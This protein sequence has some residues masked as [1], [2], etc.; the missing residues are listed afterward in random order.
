MA[1]RRLSATALGMLSALALAAPTQAQEP[2]D[3]SFGAMACQLSATIQS[4]VGAIG[5][6]GGI[7][8][9]LGAGALLDID[10]HPVSFDGTVICTGVDIAGNSTPIGLP[11][12]SGAEAVQYEMTGEGEIDSLFCGT[13]MA[14][15]AANIRSSDGIE[16][17][18]DLDL[19]LALVAG[20]GVLTIQ[21]TN[22]DW[23][24]PG[25]I[26]GQSVTSGTGGGVV[27]A[28]PD[29]FTPT[30]RNCVTSGVDGFHVE[31]AFATTFSGGDDG[32]Q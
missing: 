27:E 10:T 31:G 15:I 4:W 11:V 29:G 26:Y 13:G 24:D 22:T 23:P 7:V 5:T 18:V 21:I 20:T 6:P 28:L 30:A 9:D 1:H 8:G 32:N 19:G 14:Q 12:D 3:D 17:D 2:R 25:T 16:T